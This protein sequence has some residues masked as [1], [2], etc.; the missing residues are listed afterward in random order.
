MLGYLYFFLFYTFNEKGFVLD[1]NLV[2]WTFLCTGLILCNSPLHYIKLVNNASPTVGPI[3]LQYP[4][5]AGIMGIMADTG[6][7][8]VLADYIVSFF[9]EGNVRFLFFP[10]RW[11]R[12]Y[13]Y[14]FRWRSMGCSGTG[15]D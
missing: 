3:I 14:S 4:F 5:Y 6:L 12:Q 13:V 10:F 2:S 1:L 9:I 8:K 15:D 7:I 11:S